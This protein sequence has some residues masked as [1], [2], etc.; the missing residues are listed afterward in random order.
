V[1]RLAPWAI[2]AAVALGYPLAV[3]AG[4][5]A[6]SF[7]TR[8]DCVLPATG[9][10]DLEA[11]FGRFDSQWRAGQLRDRALAVGFQGTETKRDACGRV[12]VYLPGIT[13]LEVGRAFAEQAR[14]A[15]FEV[16]LE[17]AG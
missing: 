9:D 2:L 3:L 7:P 8:D 15:G 10:G 17:Q 4:A 1:R 12:K 6:P 11:V 14:G 16:T 13:T 5:G